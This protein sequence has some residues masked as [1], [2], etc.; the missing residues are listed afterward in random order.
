MNRVDKPV[1]EKLSQ[2]LNAIEQAALEPI[3]MT[4]CERLLVIKN[5]VNQAYFEL[6]ETCRDPEPGPAVC[7][8]GQFLPR[9][10]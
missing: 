7:S 2:V 10:E 1:V 5:Q 9:A 8:P 4:D 6:C 3:D